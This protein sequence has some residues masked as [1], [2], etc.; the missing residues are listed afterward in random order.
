[1]R[2]RGRRKHTSVTVK[3]DHWWE[4]WGERCWDAGLHGEDC[5]CIP[6][7]MHVWHMRWHEGWSKE[8]TS[9][10]WHSVMPKSSLPL[11]LSLSLSLSLWSRLHLF[12]ADLVLRA[13]LVHSSQLFI[14]ECCSLYVCYM[15][16]TVSA[17]IP[18][19]GMDF[20]SPSPSKSQQMRARGRC[21]WMQ[22]CCICLSFG[23]RG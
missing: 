16:T 1:M 13:T 6:L 17:L 11:S 22:G 12:L 3:Q 8:C 18:G 5:I 15:V 4:K 9:S 10:R 7:K 19:N 14:Y 23:W 21:S 2:E 20:F